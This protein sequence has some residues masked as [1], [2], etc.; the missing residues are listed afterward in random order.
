MVLAAEP[1]RAQAP[2]PPAAEPGR[3]PAQAPVPALLELSFAIEVPGGS[4]PPPGA[5]DVTFTLAKLAVTGATAFPAERVEATYRDLVGQEISLAR[6]FGVAAAIEKLYK[7]AGYFLS[8]A[9]L[10]PQT[11]EDGS[12]RIEVVEGYIDRIAFQDTDKE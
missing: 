2:L 11:V 5:A 9:F 8:F 6:L 12:F 10:P 4:T 3:A 1:A 7:D